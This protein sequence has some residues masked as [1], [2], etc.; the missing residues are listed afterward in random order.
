MQK[1]RI[2]KNLPEKELQPPLFVPFQSNIITSGL[3]DNYLLNWQARQTTY[4]RLLY[5]S[6]Y[7]V[8]F[9]R[10][11]EHIMGYQQIPAQ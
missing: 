2:E 11:T 6:T 3:P 8:L 5:C 7:L 10:G 1:L 4:Q 9:H